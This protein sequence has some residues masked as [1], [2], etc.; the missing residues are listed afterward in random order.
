VGD[1]VSLGG[2]LQFPLSN[3]IA[4]IISILWDIWRH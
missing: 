2:S 4:C 3:G 1:I